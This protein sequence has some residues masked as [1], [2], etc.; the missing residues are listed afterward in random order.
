MKMQME[1][2]NRPRKPLGLALLIWSAL[3]SLHPSH[4]QTFVRFAPTSREKQATHPN[5]FC[6][7]PGITRR[8]CPPGECLI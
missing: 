2:D 7:Q 3:T 1:C 6:I 4:L 8:R 5:V